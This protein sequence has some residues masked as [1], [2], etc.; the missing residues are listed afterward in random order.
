MTDT[1]TAPAPQPAADPDAPAAR[2]SPR[3]EAHVSYGLWARRVGDAAYTLLAPDADAPPGDRLR[4]A[5]AV[6]ALADHLVAAAAVA[7]REEGTTWTQLGAA[8]ELS[9]Q[10]AHDRWAG[11]VAQ[12]TAGGRTALS[13]RNGLTARDAAA[14]LDHAR[15]LVD[16]EGPRDAFSATLHAVRFPDAEA[17][18]VRGVR[19]AAAADRLRALRDGTDHLTARFRAQAAAAPAARAAVLGRRAAV[20]DEAAQLLDE[21]ATLD[22]EQ[23]ASHRTAAEQCRAEAAADRE[24]AA[25]LDPPGARP[26]PD[27]Q[28]HE[29]F[30][31]YCR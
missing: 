21:L 26:P 31:I 18:R 8:A 6:A 11:P 17:E 22:P 14:N 28:R 25:L 19:A 3:D 7:E 13:G 20:Q 27:Q 10:A 29:T 12:W 5:L 23:A 30:K 16:P 24:F 15:A 4:R 1:D 2:L 9:K